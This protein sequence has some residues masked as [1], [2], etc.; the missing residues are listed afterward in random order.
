MKTVE[1]SANHP[2]LKVVGIEDFGDD[3]YHVTLSRGS[4][5][6]TFVGKTGSPRWNGVSFNPEELHD[7]DGG[8]ESAAKALGFNTS[9]S[10]FQRRGY[11]LTRLEQFLGKTLRKY[12]RETADDVTTH[13][14]GDTP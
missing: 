2:S 8:F 7:T 11:V 13:A 3:T 14:A 9:C 5:A 1:R 6:F 10:S 4:K 12:L